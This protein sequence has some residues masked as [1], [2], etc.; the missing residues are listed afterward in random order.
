MTASWGGF[1]VFWNKNAAAIYVR[2]QRYTKEFNDREDTFSLSFFEERYRSA[3]SLCGSVSGR[4][5]DKIARTA[6]TGLFDEKAPDFQEACFVLI[7]RKLCHVNLD[8]GQ[9]DQKQYDS[10]VYPN[11][12]YHRMYIAEILKVLQK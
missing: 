5:E 9:F 11:K 4:N 1:E 12:D 7:C 8:P 6:L 10:A 2:S 3:L